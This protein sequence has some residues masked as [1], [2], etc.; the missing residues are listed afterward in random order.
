MLQS[1]LRYGEKSADDPTKGPGKQM[2]YYGHTYSSYQADTG[3]W[4]LIRKPE[5]GWIGRES[6]RDATC[7]IHDLSKFVSSPIRMFRF[8]AFQ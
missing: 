1:E 8:G 5:G 7:Q 3:T 2:A 6:W 4:R